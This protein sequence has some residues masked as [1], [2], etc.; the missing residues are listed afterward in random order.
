MMMTEDEE[1]DAVNRWHEG[2]GAAF[3]VPLHSYLGM[4]WAEYVDHMSP[5]G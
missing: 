1:L 3:G 4:T 5:E 2:A